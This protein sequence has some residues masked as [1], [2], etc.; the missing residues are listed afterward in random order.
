[1]PRKMPDDT[2]DLIAS[3]AASTAANMVASYTIQD[4]RESSS[5]DD[6]RRVAEMLRLA[7]RE[8]PISVIRALKY[9]ES[10]GR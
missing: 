6:L 1:M 7:G 5:V 2:L 9:A 4:W 8:L 10:I 3:L